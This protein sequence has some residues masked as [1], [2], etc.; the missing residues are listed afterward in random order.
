M[1]PDLNAYRFLLL[2]AQGQSN[3]I[4]PRAQIA[5]S[6][7]ALGESDLKKSAKQESINIVHRRLRSIRMPVE[8]ALTRWRCAYTDR[9]T[10]NLLTDLVQNLMRIYI[11]DDKTVTNFIHLDIQV[12]EL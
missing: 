4:L 10:V 7:H 3:I 1:R 5:T 6:T 2:L 12:F 11:H 9:Q 8:I